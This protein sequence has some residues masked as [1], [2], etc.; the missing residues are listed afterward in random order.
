MGLFLGGVVLD[1]FE[2][3]ARIGFG[4]KQKLAVH[5]L[6]GGVRVIDAMGPDDDV[7]AWHGILSGGDAADRAQLLDKLRVSGI[8]VPLAWDVFSAVVIVSD[9]KLEFQ[10]SWW[11]PYQIACTVLVGTQP[12]VLPIDTPDALADI[13]GD[14]NEAAFIPAISAALA[15]VTA[16]GANVAGAQGYAVALT[17]LF[18]AQAGITAAIQ[19][20]D[21]EMSATDVPTLVTSAG[22]LAALTAA[23]GFVGRAITN[24]VN[25]GI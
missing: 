12:T 3:T 18:G 20:A 17:S 9:L 1:G 10:N 24:F 11:I 21:S 19:T 15:L 13:V 7:I 5:K 25:A 2:V 23:S 16:Q 8:A 6:P 14:L 4:G 22:S